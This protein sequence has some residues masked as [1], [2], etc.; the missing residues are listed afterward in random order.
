MIRSA[1]WTLFLMAFVAATDTACGG[2]G[3][4]YPI[5]MVD[6]YD[7]RDAED[8]LDHGNAVVD[9]TTRETI[10]GDD[11][12]TPGEIAGAD[13][14]DQELGGSDLAGPDTAANDTTGS[15]TAANDTTANDTTVADTATG[16]SGVPF[17][18]IAA[19][20]SCAETN[21]CDELAACAAG[22]D[23]ATLLQ[24]VAACGSSDQACQQTCLQNAPAAGLANA[25]TLVACV[26]GS[27][28]KCASE[29]SSS[30]GQICDSGLSMPSIPA[31]GDC[32]GSKCCDVVDSCV[33]DANCQSC[34]TGSGGTNCG[35][36]S[37]M[38]AIQTCQQNNCAAE[39]TSG[40]ICDS[41]LSMSGN[42][43]CGD[44]LGANCCN[45][46]STCA[47]DSACMDCMTGVT[48]TGC[49]AN[50]NVME[51]ESCMSGSCGTQCG[52]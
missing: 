10:V 20:Q 29:C 24:C 11:V 40:A 23:C 26:Q 18:S 12:Q 36:D 22:T 47:A 25:Q 52:G 5:A 16:C 49:S 46:F 30:S 33:A 8:A 17:S 9:N 19:C 48:T 42:A 21:C 41:G 4:N 14:T 51:A 1:K 3:T 45:Q 27:S 39:C 13:T 37:L 2:S 35:T 34:V 28:G 7:A 15:D 32:L 44:C 38:A 50:A 31:C 43:A 6:A